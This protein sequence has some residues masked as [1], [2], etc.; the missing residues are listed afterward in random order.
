MQYIQSYILVY[1]IIFA[2]RYFHSFG[3]H[4]GGEI[5]EGLISQFSDVFITVNYRHKLKW[6]LFARSDSRNSRNKTTAKITT[7]IQYITFDCDIIRN[8]ECC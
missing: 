1:T 7:Y 5:R 3:L 2:Y 8:K 6:K 4:V